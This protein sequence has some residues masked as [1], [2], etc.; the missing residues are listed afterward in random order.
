M[1]QKNVVTESTVEEIIEDNCG[2]IEWFAGLVVDVKTAC[3][4][5]AEA[6]D[7]DPRVS[8]E[9]ISLLWQIANYDVA[10]PIKD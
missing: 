4:N 2:S 3:D 6:L 8:E 10:V 9:F 1:T 5:A 7:G